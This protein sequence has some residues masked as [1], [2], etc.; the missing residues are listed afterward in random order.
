M[1]KYEFLDHPADIKIRSFGKDLPELFINS[2]LGMMEF[3]YGKV[4]TNYIQTE[5]IEVKANNLESL[6]VDWLAEILY[7]SDTN[8]RAYLD[9]K[10]IEFSKTKI[11]ADVGS[12]PA[13]A[14]DDIKAVTYHELS[15]IQQPDGWQATVVYDI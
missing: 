5:Q 15:I 2:A 3:L 6:L 4:A 9:Y 1:K 10:I 12:Q 14:K 11:I 8:K 13:T 7:L